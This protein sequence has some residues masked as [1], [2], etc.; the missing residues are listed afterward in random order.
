M[1]D[2]LSILNS[3]FGILASV[4]ALFCAGTAGGLIYKRVKKNTMKNVSVA[5][6]GKGH[7]QVVGNDN[8]VR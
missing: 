6:K 2:E 5:A 4:F 7:T 1:I 3:G 8:D